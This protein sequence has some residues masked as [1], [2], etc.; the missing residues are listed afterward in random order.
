CWL[1]I[2][3][4]YPNVQLHE[5]VIM[6]NHMHGIIEI[7]L[8]ESVSPP[9]DVEPNHD[10]PQLPRSPSRTIGSMVRGYKI[11]VT[12]WFREHRADQYPVGQRVW[13]RNYWEHI[14]RSP[15]DHQR[16]AQ[17]IIDNPKTWYN[18]RLRTG[19]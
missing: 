12:K 4:H 17:Y 6:P 14:I 1:A 16:I 18:D 13:Q 11:G 9:P 5:Y 7:V 2:P 10:Q 3:E 8:S 19:E 15:A